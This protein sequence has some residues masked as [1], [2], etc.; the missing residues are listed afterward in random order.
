MNGRFRTQLSI[1]FLGFIVT[2]S[3]QGQSL[4]QKRSRDG[5]FFKVYDVLAS[6]TAIKH[7]QYQLFYKD[8]LIENGSHKEGR[9]CSKWQFFSLDG[10]FEF[11]FD[12]DENRL[13]KLSGERGTQMTYQTPCLFLG[14][15][16]IPYI[17]IVDRMRY[18][19]KAKE[20][21]IQGRV[22]LA[23]KI[24]KQGE[25]WSMYLYEKLHPLL[26]SE[27]MRVARTIP[28]HWKWLPAT[29]NGIAINGEYHIAIEFEMD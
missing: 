24:N 23:L 27:V 18:P 13:V 10:V 29:Q 22:V 2:F 11:E 21:D 15:P 16:I 7:G 28:D 14:S 19:D 3:S 20:L 4:Q 5:H 9:P 26:D 6:D 12:F 8:K 25:L 1:V 17:Y